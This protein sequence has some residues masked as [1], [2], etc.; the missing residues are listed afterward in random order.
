MSEKEMGI[1]EAR[2]E[3]NKWVVTVTV[4]LGTIM[5]VLDSSIVNVALPD[6]TSTFGASVEQITWVVTGYILANVIIMP[7][8]ALLTARFGRKRFYL[9]SVAAFTIASMA[10]GMAGTLT[11]MVAARAIQGLG[12]GVLITLAQ[13]ILRETFPPEEQG[14]AMG[15]YGMGVVLAPAIGPTL[16]GWLTDVHSWP[17][18][19]FINVPIGALNL[20]M[21]ARFIHDPPY[22]VREKGRIDWLGL[23]LMTGG[24]GGLQLMLEQGDRND[25]FQSG[26]IMAL[27]AASCIGLVLFVWRELTID[28]PAVD[29]RILKNVSFASATFIGGVLGMALFGSVFL[30]PLYLQSLLGYSAMDAGLIMM[31]RSLAMALLM[32]LSGRLYNRVGPRKLVAAGLAVS[33]YGFYDLSH[34]TLDVGYWDLFLPQLWQGVGF[35]LVFV[36]LST[37]A[38]ATI[39]R[40]QMTAAAGLYNVVRQVFG[41][42]GVSLAAAQLARGTATNHAILAEH[43]TMYDPVSRGW[44]ERV[45]AAMQAGGADAA[46][47]ARRALALLDMQMLRQAAVIAYNHIFV[48]VAL[49]F[50]VSLPLVLLLSRAETGGGEVMVA[51]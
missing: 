51:E 45:T 47:A 40:R 13:A 38:L 28:R 39:D 46:T 17:W 14:M 50:L 24:L 7:I 44:V 49:L 19:F 1:A 2:P 3:T 33:A 10:C 15:V 9:A 8:L 31:P 25:W 4:M 22:L 29:L 37:A 32:P 6:M 18:V 11:T 36:A 21:I 16:G 48:L 41:S 43:V 20:L 34:L 27:T 5:A 35:S 42:I 12:G 26:Y 23:A 30:L